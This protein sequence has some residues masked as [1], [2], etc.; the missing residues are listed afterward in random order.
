METGQVLAEKN[1]DQRR[2]PASTTKIMTALVALENADLEDEMTAS[3]DAINS[4]PYDYVTAGI[5]IGETL[6]FKDLLDLMMITS[7]NEASNIIAENISED[8][9]MKGFTDLMN[10]KAAELG[11]TGTHFTNSSGKEEEDHYTT[12]RDLHTCPLKL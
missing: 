5:K 1:P 11:L 9:T 6:K 4:V 10:K 2:S 7:A 8:G 3:E 12:A